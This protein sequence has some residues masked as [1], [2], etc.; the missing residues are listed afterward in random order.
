VSERVRVALVLSVALALTVAVLLF[1]RTD[2]T[3]SAPIPPAQL[4]SPLVTPGAV[5][6]LLPD[7]T[8]RNHGGPTGSR[9]LRPG[10]VFLVANGCACIDQIR[11]VVAEAAP[12]RLVTYVVSAGAD[13]SFAESLAAQA[14]GQAAGFAD[15]N[16]VLASA[17]RLHTPAAV[18]LVRRDGVVTQVVAAVAPSLRLAPSLA[19]L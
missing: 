8:L 6:G 7:V 15:E 10:V 16:G 9:R 18:V 14:G 3:P 4:A 19:E 5:G 2:P 1:L 11:Q 17:Y 12:Y 13:A